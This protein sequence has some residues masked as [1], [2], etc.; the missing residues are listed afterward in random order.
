MK[1]VVIMSKE[2]FDAIA[3]SVHEALIHTSW[4]EPSYHV[5]KVQSHLEYIEKILKK[6]DQE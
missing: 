5:G 1:N 6:D 4:I 3:I 2:E